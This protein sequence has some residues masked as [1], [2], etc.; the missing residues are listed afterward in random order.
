MSGG[1]EGGGRSPSCRYGMVAIIA[2]W[3]VASPV[4]ECTVMRALLGCG[5]Q[6]I[7]SIRLWS[8]LELYFL[9]VLARGDGS[10]RGFS[11]V[12]CENFLWYW[13]HGL[14]GP[15]LSE[16]SRAALK[17]P[18]R[19]HILSGNSDRVWEMYEYI[20][21][22]ICWWPGSLGGQYVAIISMSGDLGLVTVTCAMYPWR[23]AGIWWVMWVPIAKKSFL[24]ANITPALG[25]FMLG[26]AVAVTR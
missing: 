24:I 10:G 11:W 19:R 17:S 2:L 15:S 16:G 20:C 3:S 26:T 9:H 25:I 6:R 4:M 18:I 12:V 14:V 21:A 13:S 23:W 8:V 5:K 22:R 7:S 1:A